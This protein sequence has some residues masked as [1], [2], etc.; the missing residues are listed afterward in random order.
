MLLSYLKT[1]RLSIAAFLLSCL[2]FAGIFSLYQLPWQAVGYAALLIAFF[3]FLFFLFDFLS[4]RRRHLRL[5]R[6]CGELEMVLDNLPEAMGQIEADYQQL[7]RCLESDRRIQESSLK[8]RYADMVEYYTIWAHQIKTPIAAMGLLLQ[9][10]DTPNSRALTEELQKIEQYVEMV[11][12]YLRLDADSTDFLFREYD[13]DGIVRQAVRR[14]ASQFIKKK[15]RLQ[16]EPLGCTVLT[17][18]KWL[19]FVIEQILSNAI[20]YTP[21]G[22]IEISLEQPKVL[23]IRDTG[24]GIDPADLP[25]I[26]E[27]GFTGS[28]GRLDKRATGIGLGLSRR[29]L[30][31]LGHTISVTSAPGKGTTVRIGLDR[32]E[33]EVE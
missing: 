29:I 14:Y 30:Q 4:F 15:L 12:C 24:I 18:E 11:L 13:L 7:L 31:R 10:S 5:Q 16:Y 32:T 28:N 23:C 21:S 17:D 20:K 33:L 3:L 2:I 26:F 1:R 9:E 19:L 8:R 27:T 22:F 6:L 25:R